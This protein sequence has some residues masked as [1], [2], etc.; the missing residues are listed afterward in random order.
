[1]VKEEKEKAEKFQ[2]GVSFE[3]KLKDGTNMRM[4][5]TPTDVG[6]HQSL[7]CWPRLGGY[8]VTCTCQSS[9]QVSTAKGRCSDPYGNFCHCVNGRAVIIC[10][11]KTIQG[12]DPKPEFEGSPGMDPNP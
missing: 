5:I 3:F 2:G 4:R 7:I 10:D 8:E 1:M 6:Y 12:S 11:G 9:G